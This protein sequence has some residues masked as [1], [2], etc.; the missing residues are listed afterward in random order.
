MNRQKGLLLLVIIGLVGAFFYFD[1]TQ[2]LTL[3]Y[4]QTQR[5]AL[6]EWRRSE[7][8]FAAALFFVV[9]VLVTALSLPGATVMTLAIGAVFGLL[10]GLL[11]VSF[12][13]TIGATLAFV[14]ARFLLRD[15]VQSR[16]GDRLKSINAGIEKDGAFYLFTLRLVPLFPFFVINLV[17][18]LTPIKTITFYWVSQVGMLAG[19][20]VYVNAGT[21]LAGLDSLSGILSPGLI[22]SFVLLGFFPLLAKKFVALVKAR[23]AMAGWKRPAKFDRNLVVIG[24]GSAGLVSAYIAAAVKS[25]VSLIEKH[26][27]GGDCLNTGCVPSKALIRSSRILAQS[28][29]A[30]EWGFD[31]IDVKY[32]FAQIMERV[33]KVVGEVEPHDSVERYSELGVDVIQGEAK[34]TSPYVVEVDGREIT[35]RGIVVATGARPFV[36]PIPGLDQIDYLTSDNLWQ[37]RELPQ[38]LLVLGGGP[39]GCELS[40]AFARFSSQVTMV[41]MAPRLMIREDEDVAALVTERFLAEGI[42]VLVGHRATGFKVVDGEKRLLCDYDGETVEVVFDQVLVAV[43]RRPNTQ[44]FGLEALDIPLNPNG[45]IETNEY[46]ETRIPTIYACGDVAGPYQFTHTAGHQAWYVAVNSLFGS[47]K[48]F[49]VDY[50]VIPFATFT[51]PEVGRVGLNEQEAKQQGIDYE[52]TRFDL[53]E[54]DRAIAEGEAHGMVKV[55]TVPGKDKILGAT[56]VGENAGELIGEFTA[57]MRHGFG[58]NKILGT[59]HIYPTLFEAN[60]YA[61]GVWKRNHKPEKLLN[62]V[63]R[64][65]AW[66]R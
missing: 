12:A 37:L 15:T 11:L 55:L 40:Q 62:W 5:D 14:I 17:M 9:Y 45:T 24:G 28:R 21:Q 19:T 38:R 58:L 1:L 60:K 42:N 2:Y 44:G 7:P 13:S 34:I 29:R 43:G 61:A 3:E 46:L 63:E 50:S 57:A 64:F 47:F 22:G 6:I 39:I 52:V 56:I 33:Q 4:L 41:E 59:I 65:H 20:I 30:Q 23:R 31:A 25:K 8:L 36:P 35:T 32:D 49:K 16:F 54:L 66:R 18:G 51:D 53:S 26:R 48:K 27:M 10:W